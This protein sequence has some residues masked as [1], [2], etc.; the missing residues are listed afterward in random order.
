MAAI[1]PV[2]PSL[3][4]LSTM[5]LDFQE[6]P[7]QTGVAR[8]VSI[9]TVAGKATVC[10]GVRRGGKSTLLFQIIERLLTDGVPRPNILYLNFFDEIRAVPV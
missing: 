3:E 10:I 7:L 2:G 1:E 8:R 6:S 5:I 4:T 9:E